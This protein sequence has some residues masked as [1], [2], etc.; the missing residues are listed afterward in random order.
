M[1]SAGI[2]I[3]V[4]IVVIDQ[5]ERILISNLGFIFVPIANALIEIAKIAGFV[6]LSWHF[7]NFWIMILYLFC[8]GSGMMRL[9]SSDKKEKE[10]DENE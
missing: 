9:T 3:I 1:E 7:N 4:I 8:M 5:K 10:E 6:F 2:V